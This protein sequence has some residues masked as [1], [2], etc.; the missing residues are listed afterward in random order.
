MVV[1]AEGGGERLQILAR[2]MNL[3][4]I[5]NCQNYSGYCLLCV[6]DKLHLQGLIDGAKTRICVDFSS[7]EAN[8]RRKQGGGKNQAIARAIGLKKIK[9]R[10]VVDAT[11]GLGGD[12]FVLAC[13]GCEVTMLERSTIVAALLDD[14]LLRG[15]EDDMLSEIIARMTLHNTEATDYLSNL[16]EAPDVVYLDPMYPQRKKTAKVKK[17]MQLL[18]GLLPSET[19]EALLDSALSVAQDRVVIK[20]PKGAEY[21]NHSAPSHSIE[22]KK[23]RYDVYLCRE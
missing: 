15:C 5:Q 22:S 17:A 2:Q 13:L 8:Y 20:R 14:G 21:F 19:N 11:A 23:T 1:C 4:M 6:D 7:G 18:Q 12:A 16:S 3:S 10:N 9:N